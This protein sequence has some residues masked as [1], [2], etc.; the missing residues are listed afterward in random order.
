MSQ[1]KVKIEDLGFSEEELNTLHSYIQR[2]M[3]NLETNTEETV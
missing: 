2:L 3:A 1:E